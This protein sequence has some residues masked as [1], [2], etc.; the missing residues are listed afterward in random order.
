VIGGSV[1]FATRARFAVTGNV[2]DAFV[3][4]TLPFSVQFANEYPLAGVALTVA[5]LF[6]VYVPPPLVDPPLAGLLLVAIV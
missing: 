5:E 4:T 1:K 3:E 6:A 2:Y